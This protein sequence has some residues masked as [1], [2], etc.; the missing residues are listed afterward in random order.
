MKVKELISEL[1]KVDGELEVFTKKAELFG[2]I[3]NVFFVKKDC[4]S[5]F[6]KIKECIVISDF[7]GEEDED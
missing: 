3:G 6:G 1:N 2:N 5:S 4:Y 7:E